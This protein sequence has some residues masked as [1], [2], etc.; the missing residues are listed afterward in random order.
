MLG[1]EKKLEDIENYQENN[2][3]KKGLYHKYNVQRADGKKEAYQDYFVLKL[4]SKNKYELDA[5][6]AYAR[7]CRK[8]IPELALDLLEKVAY[9]RGKSGL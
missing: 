6:E 2:M 1:E 8:D 7:S 3:N 5:L 4:N 9:Y